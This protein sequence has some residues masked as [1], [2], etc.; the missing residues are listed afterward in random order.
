[1]E[2]GDISNAVVPHA[3][4]VFEGFVGLL[5]D[6]RSRDKYDKNVRKQNWRRAAAT[7]VIN[8][9]A[10]RMLWDLV[11]NVG[12]H[13]RVVT[14]LPSELRDHLALRIDTED[15]P[16][17]TME[18]FEDHRELEHVL[19]LRPHVIAVY[20][21]DPRLRFPWGHKGVYLDPTKLV[22]IGAPQ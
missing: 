15:I 6:E 8:D 5:P 16:A 20:H 12:W 4:F 2:K 11:W 9:N 22:R 18:V 7:F 19:A 13:I 10:R 17:S 14:F 3:Y 1:M 21:S